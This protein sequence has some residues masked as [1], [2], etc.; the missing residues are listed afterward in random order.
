M[1]RFAAVGGSLAYMGTSLHPRDDSASIPA[2]L[3]VPQAAQLLAIGRTAVYQLIWNGEITPI[4]IGRSVRFTVDEI[5][6]F[7]AVRMASS[8]TPRAASS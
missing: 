3:T 7:I 8:R 4:H 5:E 6:R 1:F 2:L